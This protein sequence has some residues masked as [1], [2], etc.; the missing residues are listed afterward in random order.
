MGGGAPFGQMGMPYT[1]TYI[2]GDYSAAMAGFQQG[3]G[4][5]GF[6][7]AGNGLG[8]GLDGPNPGMNAGF[9]D[10]F[11]PGQQDVLRGR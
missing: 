5:G 3:Y 10:P 2:A 6:P 4:N 9:A 7:A 1:G 8:M 11:G